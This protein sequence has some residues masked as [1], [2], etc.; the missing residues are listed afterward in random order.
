[1]AFRRVMF[2]NACPKPQLFGWTFSIFLF[3]I[4]ALKDIALEA[5]NGN[6]RKAV[7]M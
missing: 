5:W 2:Q 6:E 4:L 1:M 7:K 3:V